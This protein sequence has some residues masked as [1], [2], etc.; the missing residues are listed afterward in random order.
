M[1]RP[2]LEPVFRAVVP[3]GAHPE[4]YEEELKLFQKLMIHLKPR[5]PS[6]DA[7]DEEVGR[8][9]DQVRPENEEVVAIAGRLDEL[10]RIHRMSVI[11]EFWEAAG[12]VHPADS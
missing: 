7:S 5:L 6:R 1:S 4:L 10:V 12:Q 8:V 2:R 11:R 3:E 9:L